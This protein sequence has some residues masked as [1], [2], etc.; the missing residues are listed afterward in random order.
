MVALGCGFAHGLFV[1]TDGPRH[2]YT[3]TVAR[4]PGRHFARNLVERRALLWQLVRRDFRQRYVGSA[5]GWM[6]GVVHPVVQLLTWV[7]VFQV[8]LKITL[9]AQSVTQN[10]P[11]Y[12]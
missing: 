4:I 5:A 6:W 11:M 1:L 7:F 12:L 8:C 2:C 10:Y 9:P 3:R